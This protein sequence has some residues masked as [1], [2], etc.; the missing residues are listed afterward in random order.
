MLPNIEIN[1]IVGEN[2]P[3]VTSFYGE[4]EAS[5]MLMIQRYENA[6]WVEEV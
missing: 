3:R 5:K 1:T 4:V 2:T 6:G